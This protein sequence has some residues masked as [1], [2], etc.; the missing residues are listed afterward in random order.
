[1]GESLSVIQEWKPPD[2]RGFNSIGA[3]LLFALGAIL[4]RGLHLNIFRVILILLFVQLT[5]T[6]R[7]AAEYLGFIVPLLVAYSIAAQW[8]DA[9]SKES[10]GI[11][12]LSSSLKIL[13][14][15]VTAGALLFLW[16]RD[17]APAS[18]ISP[19]GALEAARQAGV[20]GNVLN[21]YNF[22]GFLIFNRIPVFID[23]RADMYGDAFIKR[24]GQAL[25]VQ[26]LTG[27]KSESDFLNII[28]DYDIRWAISE[29]SGAL[30]LSLENLANWKELYRDD[31]AVVHT[32]IE[33]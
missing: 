3:W 5:L 15:F 25:F 30:S 24:F 23:G 13:S 31:T 6:H 20:S 17:L 2:F 29:P 18:K 28:S 32:R 22:G 4:F 1:M 21:D 16:T 27:K 8:T 26:A 14:G 12:H 9:P 10:T 33:E 11:R 19:E 7:R